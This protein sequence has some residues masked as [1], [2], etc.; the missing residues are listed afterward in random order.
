M[1]SL[2][3]K[4]EIIDFYRNVYAL[5]QAFLPEKVHKHYGQTKSI[6]K[7]TLYYVKKTLKNNHC[8]DGSVIY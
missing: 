2:Y 8:I 6:L 4:V 7:R 3:L 5:F 1:L